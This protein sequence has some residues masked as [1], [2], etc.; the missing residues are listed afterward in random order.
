MWKKRVERGPFCSNIDWRRSFS[1][2][3]AVRQRARGLARD[4][5]VEARGGK[6]K[7]DPSLRSG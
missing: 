5:S 3:L 1:R 2:S 7:R 4:D 6:A